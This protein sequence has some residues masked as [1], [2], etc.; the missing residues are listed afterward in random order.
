MKIVVAIPVY[1]GKLPVNVVT[2]LLNEQAVAF[3]SGDEL[4]VTFIPNCSVPAA[5]R[6]SLVQSFMESDGEKLIFL[7]SDI[8]FQP[9]AIIKLAHKP[10]DLVGGAYRFKL[11]EESYPVMWVPGELRADQHGLLEVA[12]LPTGF[13]CISRK[14]FEEIRKAHPGRE[15]THMGKESYCYFQMVHKNGAMYS[16]DTY[17]C[18]EWRELGGKVYMDPEIELEHWDFAPVPFKGHIGNWLKSRIQ[19]ELTA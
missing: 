10:V 14:V 6:N 4:T 1:D 7:D 17:F 8:T 5:G 3:G 2:C 16:E 18:H 19:K 12:G 15:Y 9:G 13:M 11:K